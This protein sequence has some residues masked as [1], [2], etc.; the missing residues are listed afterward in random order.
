M[1]KK[2]DFLPNFRGKILTSLSINQTF[3]KIEIPAV[4]VVCFTMLIY[5]LNNVDNGF[6]LEY[7]NG[8][9]D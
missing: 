9:N 1:F 5:F 8:K 6:G 2:H 4:F 7:Q 3:F